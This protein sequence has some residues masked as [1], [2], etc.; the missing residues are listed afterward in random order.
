MNLR[1]ID[2][3]QQRHAYTS[4]GYVPSMKFPKCDCL[5]LEELLIV[6]PVQPVQIV[7]IKWDKQFKDWQITTL[8]TDWTKLAEIP[9]TSTVR[10][11]NSLDNELLQ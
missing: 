7:S 11:R 6:E 3:T 1:N 5:G 10:R 9:Q 8:D 4:V 2:R